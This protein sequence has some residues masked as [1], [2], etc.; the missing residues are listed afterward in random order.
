MDS[1]GG[2]SSYIGKANA[3]IKVRVGSRYEIMAD[4]GDGPVNAIDRALRKALEVFYPELKRMR[5]IDYK[6]RVIS[7]GESTAS[8]TRVLIESTDGESTW[9]TVG[10][11]KDIINASMLALTDSLEYMLKNIPV[12]SD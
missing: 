12:I 9:T 5:L 6:V 1:F 2:H 3:I 8:V 11:S 4:E 10:A 7:T